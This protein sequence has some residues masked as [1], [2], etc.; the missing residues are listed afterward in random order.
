MR[1]YLSGLLLPPSWVAPEALC[2]KIE[3]R[4]IFLCDDGEYHLRNNKLHKYYYSNEKDVIL[5]NYMDEYTLCGTPQAT[6]GEI[7]HHLP[8]EHVKK[9]TVCSL[10]KLHQ[11]SET[12]FVIE[13]CD[14]KIIDFYFES[15][16]AVPHYTLKEDISS[17]VSYLK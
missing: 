7:T 9:S 5:D 15:P 1:Y 12:S 8:H 11:Q 3:Y 6:K 16:H 10:Y 4:T 17:L 2:K 14:N 13:K